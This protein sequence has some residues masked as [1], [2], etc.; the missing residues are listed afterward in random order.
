MFSCRLCNY[1]LCEVCSGGAPCESS[2][3]LYRYRLLDNVTAMLP[4]ISWKAPGICEAMRAC[5]QLLPPARAICPDGSGGDEAAMWSP[6]IVK[7]VEFVK[8]TLYQVV[9]IMVELKSIEGDPQN[10]CDLQAMWK[11]RSFVA[12]NMAFHDTL[13]A[14]VRV[15]IRLAHV[16]SVEELAQLSLKGPTASSGGASLRQQ[17]GWDLML[18]SILDSSKPVYQVP[19]VDRYVR[20]SPEHN[21][22]FWH[23][24]PS[25]NSRP[26]TMARPKPRLEP[27]PSPLALI[28]RGWQVLDI[29]PLRVP[30]RLG[31]QF[32]L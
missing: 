27:R 20:R 4:T 15:L 25:P 8:A 12:F 19:R 28:P 24:H 31:A 23:P 32:D 14:T 9:S 2:K 29:C 11:P 10:I 6:Q 22:P 18:E 26:R 16:Y 7:V 21:L 3:T 30:V 17:G 5:V 13:S 1:D